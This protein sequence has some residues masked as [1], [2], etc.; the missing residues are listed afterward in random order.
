MLIAPEKSSLLVVDVQGKLLAA[1]DGPQLLVANCAILLQGAARLAVPVLASEQYPKGLGPT[2]PELATLIP[3]GAVVEKTH[4]S[5]A[6][7]PAYLER[8]GRMGREQAII[9]GIEAHVCVLQT[10]L[11]LAGR[12][13][14][15]FVVADAVSARTPQNRAAA[16]QRLRDEGINVV[17][18][19]MVLFEWLGRAGTPEFKELSALVK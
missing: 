19:E 2:V 16:L 18:T 5:C 9:T 12:G 1:M 17:T 11:G 6:D 15:C 3:A 7:V 8:L 10:A 13:Y 4:F 14:R